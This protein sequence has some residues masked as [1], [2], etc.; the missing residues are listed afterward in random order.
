METTIPFNLLLL[1]LL[2][3]FVFV[4][5]WN[6]TRWHAVRA[7]RERLIFYAAIAGLFSLT[8]V[9]FF[10]SVAEYFIPCTPGWFCVPATWHTYVGFQ[11]SGISF[12]AFLLAAPMGY[13]L[14]FLPKYDKDKQAERIVR[15]E[16]GPLEQFLEAALKSQKEVLVTLTNE[17]VY[18]GSIASSFPPGG[19]DKT[20]TLLPSASG[21]R[22]NLTHRLTFT[23]EYEDIYLKLEAADPDQIGDFR[24]TIPIKQVRSVTVFNRKLHTEHFGGGNVI[25]S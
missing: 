18:L 12:A 4:S 1:P 13:L 17:K 25:S 7:S 19:R 10:K 24:I 8:V 23:T 9:F 5:T 6:Y 2:G 15:K 16:G 20:I 22:D 21:Y 14:N 11:Y 3:G